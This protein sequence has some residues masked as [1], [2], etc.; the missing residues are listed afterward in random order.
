VWNYVSVALREYVP[1]GT[2]ALKYE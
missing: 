1:S 2:G